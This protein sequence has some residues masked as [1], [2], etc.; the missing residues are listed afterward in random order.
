MQKFDV[1]PIDLKVFPVGVCGVGVA[2]HADALL[3]VTR[4]MYAR[5]DNYTL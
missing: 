5:R 1:L 4:A 2:Y 3:S